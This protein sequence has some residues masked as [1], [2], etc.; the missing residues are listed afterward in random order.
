MELELVRRKK[1]R[2][3][4]FAVKNSCVKTST[5]V[6]KKKYISFAHQF[7]KLQKRIPRKVERHFSINLDDL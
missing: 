6:E 5:L 4:D 2:K 1:K 3:K 7:R